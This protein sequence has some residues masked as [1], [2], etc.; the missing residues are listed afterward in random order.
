MYTK[1]YSSFTEQF[2][3]MMAP[4]AR[5]NKLMAKNLEDLTELSMASLRERAT[6]STES[7]KALCEVKDFQSLTAC[8]S[9]QMQCMAKLSQRCVDDSTRL[10]EIMKK[11]KADL[12]EIVAETS[13]QT[14]VA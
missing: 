6:V 11:F 13:A 3:K 7:I 4:Y 2:E 1:M 10:T 8:T 12:D 5:F 14:K 9:Q